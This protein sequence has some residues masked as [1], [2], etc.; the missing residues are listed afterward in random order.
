[1]SYLFPFHLNTYLMDL[2]PLYIF[3][4]FSAERV[5]EG[6]LNAAVFHAGALSVLAHALVLILQRNELMVFSSFPH[7]DSVLWGASATEK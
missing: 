7:G 5:K 4:S 1:M 2:R 6:W 3:N